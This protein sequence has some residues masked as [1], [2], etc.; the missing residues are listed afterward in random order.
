MFEFDHE[1]RQLNKLRQM[2]LN[3]LRLVGGGNAIDYN[4]NS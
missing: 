2:L 3:F 1:H 4:K